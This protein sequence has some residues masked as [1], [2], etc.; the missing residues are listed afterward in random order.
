[1]LFSFE[2]QLKLLNPRLF[3]E[4]CAQLVKRDFP[5]SWHM[6]GA[7][8]DEGIDIFAGEIDKERRKQ[9]GSVLRVWQGSAPTASLRRKSSISLSESNCITLCKED[10]KWVTQVRR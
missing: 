2:D 5:E 7:G 1:M 9:T 10:R 3:E 8:G 6:K 4:L